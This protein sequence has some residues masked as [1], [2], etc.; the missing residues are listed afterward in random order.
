MTEIGTEPS[1]RACLYVLRRRKWWVTSITLLGFAGG[2]A[3]SLTAHK[4]YS[5][6]AQLLVQR[7][8]GWRVGAL[9]GEAAQILREAK[10]LDRGTLVRH[11]RKLLGIVGENRAG[12]RG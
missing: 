6:T 12:E 3:L 7:A 4:Q 9:A 5:A 8:S 10:Y 1:F 2:F 11:Y